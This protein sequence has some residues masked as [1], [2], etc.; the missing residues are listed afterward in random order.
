MLA[1]IPDKQE[2]FSNMKYSNEFPLTDLRITVTEQR[3]EFL[4]RKTDK[5]TLCA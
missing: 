2:I 4:A 1:A 3:K 5:R